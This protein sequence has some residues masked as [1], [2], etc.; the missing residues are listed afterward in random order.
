MKDNYQSNLYNI[1]LKKEFVFPRDFSAKTNIDLEEMRMVSKISIPSNDTKSLKSE[2]RFKY[3]QILNVNMNSIESNRLINLIHC[4][5]Y[6]YTCINNKTNCPE[7]DYRIEANYKNK[8]ISSASFLFSSIKKESYITKEKKIKKSFC[9]I[10]YMFTK[11]SLGGLYLLPLRSKVPN[12]YEKAY[13]NLDFYSNGEGIKENEKFHLNDNN[14]GIFIDYS[15]IPKFCNHYII[16][17]NYPW[18]TYLV[19]LTGNSFSMEHTMYS[20]YFTK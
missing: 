5:F 13:I 18:M 12:Q 1:C 8:N 19:N 9:C 20:G 10:D 11:L 2:L 6:E 7:V 16:S 3:D 17:S 15:F 14:Q 4:D